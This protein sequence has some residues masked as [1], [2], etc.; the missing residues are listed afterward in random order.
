MKNLNKKIFILGGDGFCGWPTAL[1]LSRQ[2][3][4][5]TILDSLVRRKI[6]KKLGTKSLTPIKSISYEE[7]ISKKILHLKGWVKGYQ[8]EILDH[9]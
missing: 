2:G 5:V 6:D 1:Y 7:L 9:L 3:Y 8:E 4:L